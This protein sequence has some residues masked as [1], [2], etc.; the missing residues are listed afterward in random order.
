MEKLEPKTTE[1][2]GGTCFAFIPLGCGCRL[3][4]DN[5]SRSTKVPLE[6]TFRSGTFYQL[7]LWARALR[8]LRGA[9]GMSRNSQG[10][11]FTMLPDP[12]PRW[13]AFGASVG[14][15]AVALFLL[16]W[17]P[18]LLPQ[19]LIAVT[20]YSVIRLIATR[21][22]P[23]WKPQPQLKSHVM[24]SPVP[25]S[26]T[27]LFDAPRLILPKPR[28]REVANPEAPKIQPKFQSA[29]FNAPVPPA[30]RA[31]V[32][33]GGFGDPNGLPA[34]ANPNRAPN[35]AHLGSFDLP[36]GAGSGNGTG[37]ARGTVVSAGF[38]KGVAVE[39]GAGQGA[40]HGTVQAGLF[41]DVRPSTETARTPTKV[42][43]PAVQPVEIVWKPN[44]AY[45]SEAW[46]L[47]LEG[48]VLLEV[49]FTAAGEVRVLRV[50]KGLGHGLDEAAVAAARQIRF[51]PERVNGQPVDS[52][53]TVHIVF[54]LA[55]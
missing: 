37:R 28:P 6:L 32:Q 40:A 15:Q 50:V 52:T 3:K 46:Q 29:R 4:H 41:G 33:T 18:A 49:T 53:A 10:A 44:P 45:T 23:E 43:T 1:P 14:M 13:S 7:Q 22:V 51:K 17:I 38:G 26:S 21:P 24:P 42:V 16:I 31:P 19:K 5:A 8:A 55:Y 36:L 2:N 11:P 35:V 48:K 34:T 12:R 25:Q 9:K 20:R 30:R 39:S 47:R 54:Q 27:S